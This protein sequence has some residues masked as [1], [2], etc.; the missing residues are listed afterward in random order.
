MTN[1][2]NWPATVR[3]LGDMAEKQGLNIVEL[4]DEL[5]R[6]AGPIP[7]P[8]AGYTLAPGCDDLWVADETM[9]RGWILTPGWKFDTGHCINVWTVQ[10]RDLTPTEALELGTALIQAAQAAGVTEGE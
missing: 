10:D 3:E 4:M 5:E 7:M 9:N 8:P 6:E 2:T 1:A